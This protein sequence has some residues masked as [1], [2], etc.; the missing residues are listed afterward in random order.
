MTIPRRE[1]HSKKLQKDYSDR[2]IIYKDDKVK[3]FCHLFL[4]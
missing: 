1:E 2:W 4:F 3:R